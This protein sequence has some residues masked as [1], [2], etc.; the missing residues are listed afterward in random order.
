[1][2]LTTPASHTIL[3]RA[4]SSKTLKGLERKLQSLQFKTLKQY[5]FINVYFDTEKKEHVAWFYE[6]INVLKE[7]T[8]ET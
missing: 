2:G 3:P 6:D 8:K 7:I 1:M 5:Q 4:M